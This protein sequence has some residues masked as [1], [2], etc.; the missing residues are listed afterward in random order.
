MPLYQVTA[1][2]WT[3]RGRRSTWAR[4]INAHS[5][6]E[7]INIAD[8][9]LCLHHSRYTIKVGETFGQEGSND[10]SE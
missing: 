6:A 5:A 1:V 9:I 10:E 7:A 3:P 2:C 8:S 4:T